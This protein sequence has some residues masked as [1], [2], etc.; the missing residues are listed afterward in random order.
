MKLIKAILCLGGGGLA[1]GPVGNK[2]EH[3]ALPLEVI[4][5]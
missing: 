1:L 5:Y 2:R 3:T 4:N